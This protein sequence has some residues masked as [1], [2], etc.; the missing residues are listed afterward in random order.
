MAPVGPSH[1]VEG[2][3]IGLRPHKF[4]PWCAHFDT[5]ARVICG[6]VDECQAQRSA[7]LRFRECVRSR[8]D[9][10]TLAFGAE[11][12]GVLADSGSEPQWRRITELRRSE[13]RGVGA[14]FDIEKL[15][16][17]APH[18]LPR[19][20]AANALSHGSLLSVR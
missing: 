16:P 9:P 3:D 19:G 15:V 5:G 8:I 11:G 12:P 4:E 20:H 7:R 2:C 6:F 13:R 10:S 17:T 14:F 18:V 1:S